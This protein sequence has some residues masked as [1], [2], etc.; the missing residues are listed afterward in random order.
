M[1]NITCLKK[2][3]ATF[4]LYIKAKK[5]MRLSNKMIKGFG[6]ML[7]EEVDY[8]DPT[9]QFVMKA[10]TESAV[11]IFMVIGWRLVR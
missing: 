9:K 2:L 4:I 11:H 3:V 6:R 1:R 8:T 10:Q 5:N 7:C